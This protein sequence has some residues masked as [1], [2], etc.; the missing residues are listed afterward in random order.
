MT[1]TLKAA[2]GQQ[3]RQVFAGTARKT[4]GLIGAVLL[5]GLLLA[6]SSRPG[7][8][9][10]GT[11]VALPAVA[12]T[13][14]VAERHLTFERLGQAVVNHDSRTHDSDLPGASIADY[15]NGIARGITSSEA[16]D[17]SGSVLSTR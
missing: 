7:E 15:E 9:E 14:T 1:N 2:F 10:A 11:A 6:C 4:G 13:Q 17:E 8:P 5:S 3:Q 12:Q 16:R